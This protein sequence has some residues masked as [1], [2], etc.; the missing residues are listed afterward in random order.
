MYATAINGKTSDPEYLK[1]CVYVCVCV[2]VIPMWKVGG[3]Q[4]FKEQYLIPKET[5]H[6][7]IKKKRQ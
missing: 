4:S 3:A 7:P 6:V 1:G 5:L 2:G